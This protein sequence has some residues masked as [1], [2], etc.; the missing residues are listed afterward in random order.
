M[1]Q[2]ASAETSLELRDQ[3]DKA[4]KGWIGELIDKTG[5]NRLL[6]HKDRGSID[7]AQLESA[8]LDALLNGKRKLA[9]KVFPTANWDKTLKSLRSTY[10]KA[11]L[12]SEEHGVETLFLAAGMFHWSSNESNKTPAAPVF[13]FPL[14]MEP[15]GPLKGDFSLKADTSE[16]VVNPSL[17]YYMKTTFGADAANVLSQ[18]ESADV[19]GAGDVNRVV[20]ELVDSLKELLPDPSMSDKCVVG[21]FKYM[22]LP[23]VKDLEVSAEALLSNDLVAAFAGLKDA[24]LRLRQQRSSFTIAS[25]D[26]RKSKE[27]PLVL[28]AD[29]SQQTAINKVREGESLVIQ[30]PPGTGKSQTIAN[31]VAAL[32][33]DGKTVLFVAEKRAAIDAV[34]KRLIEV[35][36]GNLFFDLHRKGANKAVVA[37]EIKAALENIRD[38]PKTS[39][40]RV[41]R[42]RDRNRDKLLG[43]ASDLHSTFG[44]TERTPYEILGRQAQAGKSPYSEGALKSELLQL[45]G[46][47]FERLV[48]NLEDFVLQGGLDLLG[49]YGTQTEGETYATWSEL[50]FSDSTHLHKFKEAV[51]RLDSTLS[52]YRTDL[53][54]VLEETGFRVPETYAD[55]RDA[56]FVASTANDIAA[57][58]DLEAA[59]ALDL[60]QIR[61]DLEAGKPSGVRGLLGR[62]FDSRY[63]KAISQIR[64]I[65][66]APA[67]PLLS[68]IEWVDKVSNLKDQWAAHSSTDPAWSNAVAMVQQRSQGVE[69]E[70][71]YLSSIDGVPELRHLLTH[72]ADQ[73]VETM[74][75]DKTGIRDAVGLYQLL[76]QLRSAGLNELLEKCSQRG[77]DAAAAASRLEKLYFG[78]LA[79]SITQELASIGSFT[80]ETH[81]HAATRFEELDN[82]HLDRNK[83]QLAHRVAMKAIEVMNAHPG[84]ANLIKA[85]GNRS[86]KHHGLRRLFEEAPDVLPALRPCWTM[87]PLMVSQL[88]PNDG[89]I[90]DVVI[91]DEASQIEAARAIPSLMRAK[92]LVLAGDSEQMPPTSFFTSTDDDGQISDAATDGMES[93]LDAAGGL[94]DEQILSWHYRSEDEQLIRFS[95]EEIYESRL[96][97][98]PSCT[99][100]SPIDFCL[101]PPFEGPQKRSRSAPSE[102]QWVAE[103]VVRHAETQPGV[104]LGVIA[105][106]KTHEEAIEDKVLELRQQHREIDE[107]FQPQPEG[108][109][110]KNL[111]SVQG[112]ERDRIILSL[113]FSKN[114]KNKL[115][116]SFGPITQT[117][118]YRRLN[119][120][121]SRAKKRMT[122]A[123]SFG[124]EDMKV[125]ETSSRGIR[126]LRDYLVYASEQSR[127]SNPNST[128]EL[129]AF[130]NTVANTL[131]AKGL[132]VSTNVG[133]GPSRVSIAVH[134]PSDSDRFVLAVEC[135]GNEYVSGG[136]VRDRDVLRRIVLESRGWAFHRVW[137]AE[138][139][140]N[141]DDALERINA[142]F[143]EAIGS[144]QQPPSTSRTTNKVAI[145]PRTRTKA[146][147]IQCDR[148]SIND[149]S[150]SDLLK[151]LR[152]VKADGKNRT[153]DELVQ[154]MNQTLGFSRLGSRIRNRLFSIVSKGA[155]EASGENPHG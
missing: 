71:R 131:R 69:N 144:S 64:T 62:T 93:I 154:E 5:R 94:L 52:L 116:M 21:R 63:K 91:F 3:I 82:E 43:Y 59:I 35:G 40:S 80:A 2:S 98:F 37:Q 96:S 126:F 99:S 78:T 38:T 124:P 118:G 6:Y 22:N 75:Q 11:R 112:D 7:L 57:A 13:L 81:K 152:W 106:N 129:D 117:G 27:D 134:D 39:L 109:F 155:T 61:L 101:V 103:E 41:S 29:G 9:S 148:K 123:S 76:D 28:S 138:W 70:F 24:E 16:R 31:L 95:N 79:Q 26:Q 102:V 136:T 77:D 142:A 33:Y 135:D 20:H 120:A 87:S 90:F 141:P 88:L 30:G 47:D 12:D 84:Q 46:D 25:V 121:V 58:I 115:P 86:R 19:G 105:L 140:K 128:Q 23:M 60:P 48:E 97:A 150:D 85:E 18:I 45:D 139:L 122:V 72:V 34:T 147:P 89:P 143:T 66:G 50:R 17:I 1:H 92:Q 151:L 111:E 146:V 125:T 36:L 130:E 53:L 8:D 114:E 68:C 145:A 14:S 15:K 73:W 108:F 100:S 4:R 83:R 56:L 65:T 104:S 42:A 32:T 137:L 51:V 107:F 49:L 127:V 110:V 55:W 67:L 113:G 54:D 133:S 74:S 10:K 132:T 119:V 44:Q 149:Y 153:N